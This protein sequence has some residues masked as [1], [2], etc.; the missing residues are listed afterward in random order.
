MVYYRVTTK[1]YLLKR[2]GNN[3][4]LK[5]KCFKKIV[6]LQKNNPTNINEKVYECMIPNST[7]TTE[8]IDK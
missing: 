4:F 2:V 7:Q 5:L 3:T 6:Y 8:Q 1:V